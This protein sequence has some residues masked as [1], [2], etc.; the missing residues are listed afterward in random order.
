VEEPL[1]REDVHTPGIKTIE[2]LAQFLGVPKSKTLKAVFYT[3]DGRVVFASVRGDLAVNE[4]KLKRVLKVNDLRLAT[5]EEVAAAGLVAGSASPVGLKGILRVADDS[6][7]LGSNFV[8]GANRPDYHI[9]NV[10]YPRDFAV[11]AMEGIATAEGGHGCP[12]CGAPLKALK[13]IEVGHVFKLGPFFSEKLGA[14]YLDAEGRQRPI[15]M[16]CYGIGVGRL[17]AA[18]IEHHHDERG[19]RFP[20]SISPYDVYL[21]ALNVEDA[22]VAQRAEALYSALQAAG[23]AVLYDDRAES[24][25]VKFNDADLL[26]FSVRV[27]VSPRTLRQGAAEVK[28]RTEEQAALV[29]MADVPRTVK[30]LLGQG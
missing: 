1:P 29:P 12:R 3:A 26:G 5:D 20:A 4:V 7:K 25:G 24:A 21:A 28:R 19:I 2:A 11:D 15:I 16:G 14:Y 27:V 18:A 22:A 13:G 17:L 8:T 23:L 6:I 30:A 10:N 9:R